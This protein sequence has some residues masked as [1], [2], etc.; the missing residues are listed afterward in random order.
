MVI[1]GGAKRSGE[2]AF[3]RGGNKCPRGLEADILPRCEV[4]AETSY[5]MSKKR[6]LMS[7]DG[8]TADRVIREYVRRRT[9]D[10]GLHGKGSEGHFVR[11]ETYR[12]CGVEHKS[13]LA[14]CG[15]G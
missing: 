14:V 6:C 9:R 1:E 8:L 13:L 2:M 5:L 3:S 10:S 7:E 15:G 11:G 4:L 12:R